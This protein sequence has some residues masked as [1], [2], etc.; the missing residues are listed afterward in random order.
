MKPA[1]KD[2]I[3]DLMA[4]NPAW[5]VS[6]E[7]L[8]GNWKFND[9]AALRAVVTQVCDL[10]DELNHHPTVTYG[11]NTLQIETTTHDAGNTITEKDVELAGRVSEMLERF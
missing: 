5:T 1:M 6:G 11:Y 4:N 7:T 8:V 2:S 9:F 3:A 10:A